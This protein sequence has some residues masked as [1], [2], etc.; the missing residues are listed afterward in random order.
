MDYFKTFSNLQKSF[1]KYLKNTKLLGFNVLNADDEN[2]LKIN[3]KKRVITYGIENIDGD[4]RAVNIRKNKWSMYSFDVLKNGKTLTRIKLNIPG[5][6]EIYNALACISVCMNYKIPIHIV[7]KSL[8]HYSGIKRRFEN[9]GSINGAKVIHDYAHHPTEIQATIDAVK[10]STN[11]RVIVV[12]QPHTYSRTKEL[13]N[14]FIKSLSIANVCYM[15]KIYA[16]RE[17]PIDGITAEELSKEIKKNGIPSK[18]FNEYTDV[19]EELKTTANSGD[20][21]LILGAGDIDRLQEYI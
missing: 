14:E 19:I 13:W 11:G 21:I 15:Y 7:K 5:K 10:G 18:S 17:N 16:A 12:F 9:I 1:E 2:L 4:I 6:H 8:E 3:R 20:I